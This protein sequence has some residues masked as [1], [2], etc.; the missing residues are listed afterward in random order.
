MKNLVI[1]T[2][3]AFSLSGCFIELEL[4]APYVDIRSIDEYE[5]TQVRETWS[6][7]TLISE[8]FVYQA[9]LD[10]EFQN[11]GDIKASSVSAEI[12]FYNNYR[13]INTAKIYL[14]DISPGN[15]YTYS[16]YTGFESI[17]DYSD[18]EVNVYWE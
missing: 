9:W 6:G 4:G 3:V 8:E 11:S 14:P 15:S 10:I 2:I 17:H 18:Y 5:T 13:L 1:I 12:L 7:R 16:F